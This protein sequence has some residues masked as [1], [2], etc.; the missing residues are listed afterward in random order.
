MRPAQNPNAWWFAHMGAMTDAF[1]VTVT[2]FSSTFVAPFT[3]VPVSWSWAFFVVPLAVGI[4][5]QR[6]WMH[7][8]QRQFARGLRPVDVATVRRRVAGAEGDRP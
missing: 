4:L 6:L 8:Y 1:I 3:G 7:A 2:A 5:A